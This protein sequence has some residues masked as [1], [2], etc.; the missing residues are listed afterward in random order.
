MAAA[1]RYARG[2]TDPPAEIITLGYI[3]RFGAQAIYGRP[4]GYGE[5]RRMIVAEN[6]V[7]WHKERSVAENWAAWANENHDKAALL[8][9]CE[10][11]IQNG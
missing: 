10:R 6:V 3:D 8:A 7:K 1:Y 4:L 9:E 5:M 2:E 11:L